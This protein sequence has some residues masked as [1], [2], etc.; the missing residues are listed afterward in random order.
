L[1]KEGLVNPSVPGA[2]FPGVGVSA[3]PALQASNQAKRRTENFRAAADRAKDSHS[4]RGK[5]SS[6]FFD[7]YRADSCRSADQGGGGAS[8]EREAR[9]SSQGVRGR[10]GKGNNGPSPCEMVGRCGAVENRG[11]GFIAR[12][13]RRFGRVQAFAR[14]SYG[15]GG[16]RPFSGGRSWR[17]RR[18]SA[19]VSDRAYLF[20]RHS[21]GNSSGHGGRA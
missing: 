19:G 2:V 18:S 4:G 21:T 3:N 8:V 7:S 6:R 15:S 12:R 14:S 1:V 5:N 9:S 13:I 11:G 17:I 10:G 16:G 20:F